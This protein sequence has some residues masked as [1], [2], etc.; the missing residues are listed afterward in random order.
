MALAQKI[1]IIEQQFLQT[2][3]DH[4]DQLQ[5]GLFRRAR[6]HTAFGDILF[7]TAGGLHHLIVGTRTAAD[8]AVAGHD[9]EYINYHA[10]FF[11]SCLVEKF[12]DKT[13]NAIMITN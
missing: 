6:R 11:M 9:N 10:R 2:G 8:P 4:S 7:A 1:V 12:P 3:T 13:R 5:F